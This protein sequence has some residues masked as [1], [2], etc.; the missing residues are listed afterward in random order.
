MKKFLAIVL[1]LAM[2][3]ALGVTASAVTSKGSSPATEE[4]HEEGAPTVTYYT[5]PALTQKDTSIKNL[6]FK[7]KDG[8]PVN[9]KVYS[10]EELASAG[11]SDAEYAAAEEQY[12]QVQATTGKKCLKWFYL[13]PEDVNFVVDEDNPLTM[14]FET[15]ATDVTVTLN[16]EDVPLTQ[17]PVHFYSCDLTG[18][19]GVGIFG[20]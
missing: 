3:L 1:S 10:W 11:L 18:F 13:L 16:G 17:N 6:T 19:G 2:I 20:N 14:E 4:K 9:M 5:G 15:E 12:K 7:D 8:N